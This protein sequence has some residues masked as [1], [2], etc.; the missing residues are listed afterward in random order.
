MD[1]D[2]ENR[3]ETR[4]TQ[5]TLPDNNPNRIQIA[6]HDH[7]LVVN[8]GLLLPGH[9]GPSSGSGKVG[10]PPRGF[11]KT[12]RVGPMLA[13]RLWRT[14]VGG[15]DVGWG[16]AC[17]GIDDADALR[18]GGTA[19][20]TGCVV[21]AP[22]TLGTILWSFRWG[23]VRQLDRVS[24]EVLARAWTAG[25]GPGVDPLTMDLDSTVCETYGLRKEGAQRHNYAG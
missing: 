22:S 12:G 7:R 20:A 21:E 4:N 2:T 15:T 10:G 24:R 3:P 5:R 17:S 9:L 6:F 16:A 8:V 18:I 11:G 13:T 25:A 14:D 23:H 1:F 19:D